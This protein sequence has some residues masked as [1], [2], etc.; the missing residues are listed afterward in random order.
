MTEAGRLSDGPGGASVSPVR[1]DRYDVAAEFRLPDVTGASPAVYRIA[2]QDPVDLESAYYDTAEFD[3]MRNGVTLRRRRGSA[4]ADW[5]LK[6][7]DREPR[8]ELTMPATNGSVPKDFRDLVVG[9]RLG[10]PLKRVVDLQISRIAHELLTD[11]GRVLATICDDTVRA[12]VP[13]E[14]AL[15]QWREVEVELGEAGDEAL[16]AA[17]GESLTRAGAVPSA[18]DG[19]VAHSLGAG[20]E[21]PTASGKAATAGGMVVADIAAQRTCL[22]LGDLALRSGHDRA[23]AIEMT[24]VATR[25]LRSVLRVFADL[26]DAERAGDLDAELAW[27]AALLDDVHECEVLRA[28]L[29]AAVLDLPAEL[30]VGHVSD[31]IDAQVRAAQDD[32][33]RRLLRALSGRRYRVLLQD[34]VGWVTAPPLRDAAGEPVDALLERLASAAHLL[35]KRL[36]R[37]GGMNGTQA[38]LHRARRAAERLRDAAQLARPLLG[39]K[40]AKQAVRNLS[41][42]LDLLA[43]YEHAMASGH[44]VR[45]LATGRGASGFTLGVLHEREMRRA[46]QA[47]R[48]ALIEAADLSRAVTSRMIGRK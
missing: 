4:D 14:A 18:I 6:L 36:R 38:D 25:R 46:E 31:E 12:D 9:I 45:E 8:T 23:D 5:Q 42:V 34:L 1:E 2:L 7:P 20:R 26:F 17:I 30:V 11:D 19:K 44:Y 32:R 22:I 13:G 16:L 35:V 15:G 21:A 24:R 41:D 40:R 27:L 33:E 29:A 37:A 10:L 39:K 48:Q 3:L 43:E 47:R 28:R